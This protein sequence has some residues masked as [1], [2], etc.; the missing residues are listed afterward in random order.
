MPNPTQDNSEHLAHAKK[1]IKLATDPSGPPIQDLAILS[2]QIRPQL[3]SHAE[4]LDSAMIATVRNQAV[5]ISKLN[6][7]LT[8]L[9]SIVAD[10]TAE[11]HFCSVYIRRVTEQLSEGSPARA[12]VILGGN[13]RAILGIDS[14]RVDPASLN[15][16]QRVYVNAKS[17][18][19]IGADPSPTPPAG[20]TAT[21]ERWIDEDSRWQAL[22]RSRDEAIV[23]DVVCRRNE[24]D[25]LKSGD[26]VR[27]NREASIVMG[28]LPEA[29][30]SDASEFSDVRRNPVTKA[31]LGGQQEAFDRLHTALFAAL[32]DPQ[33]ADRYGLRSQNVILL[34]GPPGTGKT[35]MARICA[36]ETARSFGRRCHFASVKPAEWESEWVGGTQRNIRNFFANC[37]KLAEDGFV[38][39]YIDEIESIARHRG[40]S[41]TGHHSDKALAAL[42][43]EIDGFDSCGNIC[44]IFATNRKD[45]IDTALTS[46][47]S[48][49]IRVDRPNARG[50]REIFGIHFGAGLAY[51]PNGSE[52]IATRNHLIDRAVALLFGGG[53]DA[54]IV[55]VRF[56]DGKA[57]TVRARE[58]VSGRLI[59]QIAEAARRRAFDRDAKLND[60]GIRAEDVEAGVAEAFKKLRSGLTRHSIHAYLDDLPQDIAVVAVENL[61]P[62]VPNASRYRLS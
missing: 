60:R 32:T 28:K 56:A 11:P 4:Q 47:M 51:S 14:S 27:F 23:A 31:D 46:R 37:R 48:V 6:S 21:F 16:G 8:E 34:E 24:T 35:L 15:P 54:E 38:V 39:A 57:R 18:A 49:E 1:L 19:I 7:Q 22:V 44:L 12:E 41:P 59:Q 52:S 5:A 55:R 13:R 50:A 17:T 30:A 29:R 53:D 43:A 26:L 2:G 9:G 58:L 45:L 10:L 20:E 3:G 33:R 40:S 61:S 36:E 25:E 42:L 62:R